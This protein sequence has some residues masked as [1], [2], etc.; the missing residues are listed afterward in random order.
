VRFLIDECLH[1]SLVGVAEQ[2]GHE[3]QHVNWLGLSGDPDWDL[4]QRIIKDDFTFVT[5]NA[6]DF[7]RLHAR[8]KLHAGLVIILPQVDPARQRALFSALLDTLKPDEVLVNEVI[9]ISL[10]GGEVVL[11]RYDL[12]R[13]DEA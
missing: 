13:L 4:M 5:N 3:C 6:A 1:T 10:D 8:R 9:E 7:R 11:T 12:P 2:H